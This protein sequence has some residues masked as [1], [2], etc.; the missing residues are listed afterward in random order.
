MIRIETEYATFGS[1]KDLHTFM[2]LEEI[3]E[4][5]ATTYYCASKVNVGWLTIG[6]VW[7][8]ITE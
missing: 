8:I 3:Y 5:K 7:R 2:R 4:L 6:E 1:F